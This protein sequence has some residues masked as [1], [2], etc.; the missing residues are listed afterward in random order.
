MK[1]LSKL[2]LYIPLT[3]LFNS[4]FSCDSFIEVGL[5]KSQLTTE[6]VFED[7]NT[8]EAAL[9]NIYSGIRDRGILTGTGQG[10]SN[11]LGNYADELVSSESPTNSSL[12][13][14]KNSLMTTNTAVSGFWTVS[15]NQ[16]YAANAILEGTHK[17]DKMT[18]E[19]KKQ[20]QGECYFIRALLHFYLS[21][22]FGSIPY[23]TDTDFRKN[24]KATRMPLPLI[25]ENIEADLQKALT[26]IPSQYLEQERVRPNAAAVQALLA[27]IYL[28][29]K[30]YGEA[31]NAASAVLNQNQLYILETLN[32]A[33]LISSKETIWQLHAGTAGRNTSE[34][35]Y[36]TFTA[37]PPPQVYLSGT[38]LS[39]FDAADLRRTAWIKAV[40]KNSATFYHAFKY[41][42][43]NATA[44]SK[45]YSIVFRLAE[46]FL[47]RAE[48]RA[49]QGD[50]IGAKE[51]L[52][53]VRNR[54]GLT[55]TGAVSQQEII[56][57]VVH[58]RRHELFTEQG[59]RFFD[60]KRTGKLDNVLGPIKMAW[61]TTN[62]LL[63][64]PQS[65][66][67]T[68]PNLLPQNPGY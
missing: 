14:Y 62:I 35:S 3:V 17:S 61:N 26:M 28:Y 38:L 20:L 32:T 16:I 7:Y 11:L 48:S 45:E 36:F 60:L 47:I 33:F 58:E 34:A 49:Y 56:E 27:R 24:S 19:Q 21:E 44:V 10:I 6:A 29:N 25:Y 57:A 12:N 55:N 52:N 22:L 18:I 9:L 59:H 15:Y 68:N 41:K 5:P 65:E 30:A 66:L 13:F 46:Q 42:E 31:S 67:A 4:L 37:I 54:A 2:K 23:I 53:K 64:I 1:A 43:N 8:A 39:S 40:T 63:P 51:D 50:L